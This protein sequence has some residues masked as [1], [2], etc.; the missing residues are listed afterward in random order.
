MPSASSFY[1][2]SMVWIDILEVAMIG[3]IC[4]LYIGLQINAAWWYYVL[5]ALG[6]I[7]KMVASVINAMNAMND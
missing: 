5:L 3:Y 6:V 1:L 7:V 2:R 4:L